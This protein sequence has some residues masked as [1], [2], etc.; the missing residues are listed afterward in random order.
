[1]TKKFGY[2]VKETP[3]TDEQWDEFLIRRTTELMRTKLKKKR[4]QGRTGWEREAPQY[5]WPM[6]FEHLRK[7]DPIDIINI[8]AMIL[9]TEELQS[10]GAANV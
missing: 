3:W 4:D 5:F 6:L 7:G 9:V 1:M 2:N 8:A 10:S